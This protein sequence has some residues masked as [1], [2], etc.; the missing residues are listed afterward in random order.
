M[1]TLSPCLSR[2]LDD[3]LQVNLDM[4]ID[5]SDLVDLA[6]IECPCCGEK[7]LMLLDI[8][9]S[10]VWYSA[11]EFHNLLRR[12]SIIFGGRYLIIC[13]ED[14]CDYEYEGYIEGGSYM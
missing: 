2:F 13:E 6:N 4:N 1:D 14:S 7:S 11:V 8:R 3:E 10:P 5:I 9:I 12:R